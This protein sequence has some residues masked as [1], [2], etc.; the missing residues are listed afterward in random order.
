MSRGCL[1]ST[2][3]ISQKRYNTRAV[4]VFNIKPLCSGIHCTTNLKIHHIAYTYNPVSVILTNLSHSPLLSRL[5][6]IGSPLS[7]PIITTQG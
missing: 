6:I 5:H 1:L 3:E 4:V 7:G 2:Q